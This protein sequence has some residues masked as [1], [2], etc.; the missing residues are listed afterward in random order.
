[1]IRVGVVREGPDDHLL[2]LTFH[3]IAAD[4]ESLGPLVSDLATAYG[5][6]L[7][8]HEPDWEPLSV[9]Y[10]DVAVWQ[11]GELG[12]LDDPRS[13]IAAQERFWRDRLDALPDLLDLPTDR[14]RPAEASQRG[15]L[16]RVDIPDGIRDRLDTLARAH[17]ATP[18]M[19]LHAA[20]GVALARTAA[21]DDVAVATPVAGR[22]RAELDPLVGMFVNSLVLR[23]KVDPAQPFGTFLRMVAAG[24]ADAF[25]HADLPFEHLVDVLAPTRSTAFAPLAQVMLTL[26]QHRGIDLDAMPGLRVTPVDPGVPAARFDLSVG[27]S[28]DRADDGS[29][30]ALDA[31]IVYATDLFDATTVASFGRRIVAVLEAAVADAR[32]PVGAIDLLGDAESRTVQTL[33]T[34]PTVHTDPIGD[35]D[36]GIATESDLAALVARQIVATPTAPALVGP[37]GSVLDYAGLGARVAAVVEDLRRQGVGRGEAVGV[38]IDRSVALVV[39]IHGIVAA[40]AQYVPIAVD[41][42]PARAGSMLST[43]GVR[44]V[45]V[46]D[47]SLPA[48]LSGN[49]VDLVPVTSRTA[50]RY[51]VARVHPDEAAYTLFTSGSTGTPKGVTVSHRAVINRLGWMQDDHRIDATDT[52]V[53]KT[54]VTFDVSVWELF[55][56]FVTGAR[57]V[58][59]EPGRHGDPHH[60]LD[61][62][63]RSRATVMHFVPSMLGVFVDEIGDGAADLASLRLVVTSGEALTAATARALLAA[64]PGLALHNLYGPTE[65]AVD[66]T[67]HPVAPGDDPVPIGRPVANTTTWVLDDRLAPVST[68]VAGELYLGGVQLARGYASRPDLTADRFV[69]DPLGHPG[70]RLYRTGDRVRWT[71]RGVLEYLGRIDF[72]VKIRGQRIEIGEIEAVLVASPAVRSAVVTVAGTGER[73]RIVGHVVTARD[74]VTDDDLRE[75]VRDLPGYMRPDTWVRLDAI[76]LTPSGKA[77]RRAL[78]SPG[79]GPDVEDNVAP[80]GTVETTIARIVGDVLGVENPSATADFF[81]LGGTSLSATRVVARL[82]ADF[83]VDIGV[84]ALFDA[85]TIS[86]LAGVVADAP[87]R[88]VAALVPRER[89]DRPPLS[90]AQRRMW[91]VEQ[92][93]PGTPSSLIPIA[94]RL[95][96]AID[97]D[98]LRLAVIDVLDR[99]EVLRTVYP[100]APD[101][102]PWQRVLAPATAAARLDWAVVSDEAAAFAPLDTGIDLTADLPMRVRLVAGEPSLLV[103]VVHHIAADGESG[104]V[105][106]RDLL[107]AYAARA[108]GGAPD[109]APLPV[110]YVDHALWQHE[111]LTAA[112]GL[113]RQ[114]AYW[115]TALACAP[116]ML[117]LPA[118]RPRPA[119]ASG[120]AGAVETV[121]PADV[122]AAITAL[123]RRTGTTPFMVLHA[124]LAALL[125]RLAGTDDVVVATAVAGRGVA[126]LDDLVGM[127]VNTIAL[128]TP[129][130]GSESFLDLMDTVRHAD[131]DA[132]AHADAP[133]EDVIERVDAVRS[134]ASAP[135]AQIRLTVTDDVAV[136]VAANSTAPLDAEIV[137]APVTTTAVDL[138]FAVATADDDEWRV[139][140]VHALDLF[141]GDT[142]ARLA[143]R[144]VHVLRTLTADPEEVV[145]DV[146]LLLDDERAQ[147]IP[148]PLDP[149][150]S[151][152]LPDMLA[153]AAA[154]DP[155]APAVLD[156]GALWTHRELDLVS[157]VLARDLI[158]R[159]IGTE[160][161][162]VSA[163]AR[164][165]L[166]QVA[167][168]AVAKAGGVYCPVDPRHPEQRVRAVIASSGG[169]LALHDASTTVDTIPSIRLDAAAIADLRRRAD[170]DPALGAPLTDR[171]RLRPVRPY[172]GAYLIHTSGSTGTPKGVLVSHTGLAGMV[173]TLR[174]R[175]HVGPDTRWLGISSPAF[176]V[177]MLEVLGAFCEGG[178]MVVTPPE[179]IGGDELA[180][181]IAATAPTH[182]AIVTSVL[183]SLRDPARILIR[184][185]LVG[186]EAVPDAEMRRWAGDRAFY[187]SYGPTETTMAC[188]TS[189]PVAPNASVPLGLPMPG[190]TAVVLDARLQ[191]VPDGVR[192]ELYL[193]GDCL[194]RGYHGRPDLTADRFVPC[195][196]GPP[197]SRMYRT[198]DLV[199]RAADGQLYSDGRT[200]HQV[201]MRG[202]RI[203]LGEVESALT[204][205]PAVV[206]AAVVGVGE[207]VTALA[208]FVETSAEVTTADLR[209]FL[210]DA[211]PSH[212]VP[213]TLTVLRAL[214]RTPIGKIDRRALVSDTSAPS[215]PTTPAG[216]IADDTDRA[217]AVLVGSVLDIDP[218]RLRPDDDFAALGGTSLSAT[219][220][221][222]RVADE[223]GVAL[224]VRDVLDAP[225]IAGLAAR[226]RSLPAIAGPRPTAGT[227]RPEHIPLSFAQQRIWF[228][229]QV[230]PTSTAYTVPIGVRLRGPLDVVALR[231]AVADVVGRHEVLRTV[232]PSAAGEPYQRILDPAEAH[233]AVDVVASTDDDPGAD[234]RAAVAPVATFDV[235]TDLPLRVRVVAR[236]DDDWL[237]ALVAHHIAVDG[238]SARPLVGDL[239]AAYSA[240]IAGRAPLFVPLPVQFADHALW[241]REAFGAADDAGS[242]LGRDLR[243]WLE[244]LSDAPSLIPLPTDR[245]RP[246]VASGRTG[247]VR[248]SVPRDLAAAVDALARTQG[249]STFMVV[250]AAVAALLARL[251]G[252]PDILVATPVSG[253]GGAVVDDVV[254]MFVSTLALRSA[255][256]TSGSFE[257]LLAVVRDDDIDAFDR[258]EVPFDLLVD[259]LVHDRSEAFAPLAQ[260]M[261]AMNHAEPVTAAAA[262]DGLAVEPLAVGI[263][264]A[265]YD[266]GITVTV[267]DVGSWDLEIVHDAGLFERTTI[268][269]WTRM[270]LS[271]LDTV[272]A[273]PRVPVGD[274]ALLDAEEAVQVRRLADGGAA[275]PPLGATLAEALQGLPAG[276]PAATAVIAHRA[277]GGAESI[278][279]ADLAARTA[280]L[281]ADL[282]A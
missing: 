53:G 241:Q 68:G 7:D 168:W 188:L 46:E 96:G 151:L 153:A 143:R 146:D 41:A 107:A 160:D 181:W 59:A 97:V 196:F 78:P 34:G 280:R 212:L 62:V 144:W 137:S 199:R 242:R 203:E 166:V 120:R 155:D 1:P 76:P 259:R 30:R 45:L 274:I 47:G 231:G 158:A 5:A 19:A 257:N 27:F 13:P 140:V 54:P 44:L 243:W 92:L 114:F 173:A 75:A 258:A 141:D 163:Q 58:L 90:S 246:P 119:V 211:L 98:T 138:T 126:D 101:G 110:Q 25:A 178:A 236:A 145:G 272:T 133:F 85:P 270:L 87:R 132:F 156:A 273:T 215:R 14:P 65:A 71:A 129:V 275:V 22:G 147:A 207:P 240:R 10:A 82:S 228:L 265:R 198:G 37:D 63:K 269:R 161:V 172:N 56:P 197:G 128:R 136:D 139:G 238:Q 94:L 60:L 239:I 103:L 108:A 169:V 251:T 194:A 89:P 256:D 186:G 8:G 244:R 104:P 179:V 28:A 124:A 167:V 35:G 67:A 226:I 225:T 149:P 281:S 135:L 102:T 177:A 182:T 170:E 267:T 223:M 24:D 165:A 72:Q 73:A 42:P 220:L 64:L 209:G 38:C 109:W 222:A 23:T 77:D 84:R 9:Q 12:A 11:A 282:V 250:H 221:I 183:A 112:G 113:D 51:E 26:T 260:V 131:L 157:S 79:P 216:T 277:D 233:V 88:D 52:I 249:A 95:R 91:F 195:P 83:G 185:L 148:A 15:G 6:R 235:T 116:P 99:H 192:G 21:T 142:A 263:P 105:L 154:R 227:E 247:V 248:E 202:L 80:D 266:L 189:T 162:V 130:S 217:V 205:H 232:F 234:V 134:D 43:A 268:R 17:G 49:D 123:S 150:A 278:T 210:A 100:T 48:A 20:L 230:D 29:L 180:A 201:K 18:F 218:E 115:E 81:G 208:G 254:G 219:R 171:D 175:H 66:V 159:G 2:V 111:T 40:G 224:T 271:I 264:A 125:H 184:H 261:L 57:L 74:D 229:N 152:L 214:P 50:G 213:A 187:D 127:F 245:P 55:W 93:A 276:D 4:G 39:A 206:A 70:S 204:A 279:Y 191:P 32:V 16:V 118:D 174:S 193:S 121:I 255:V 253:R 33:S 86:R 237:V 117:D 31:E 122:A 190:S 106:L 164:T 176:D 262:P 252:T 61:L 36:A 69:A 3:H 200:D